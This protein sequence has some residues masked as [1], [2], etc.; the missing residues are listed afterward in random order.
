[1]GHF[2]SIA[3]TIKWDTFILSNIHEDLVLLEI[4]RNVVEQLKEVALMLSKRRIRPK[5]MPLWRCLSLLNHGSFTMAFIP[6]GRQ[7]SH[8]ITIARDWMIF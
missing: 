1:V 6:L 4:I 2:Y 5:L 3:P 7:N 8:G